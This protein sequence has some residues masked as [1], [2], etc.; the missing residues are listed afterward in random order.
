EL[1]PRDVYVL[2]RIAAINDRLDLSKEAM[3]TYRKAIELEPGFYKPY[4]EFGVFFY[5]R[6]EYSQAADQLHRAIQLA[7]GFYEAYLYLGAAL[8]D[9]GQDQE[10]ETVF[11]ES[12][13]L[14]DTSQAL[15]GLGA[16]KAYQKLD[17]EALE[18]Y[19]RSLKLDPRSYV[20]L[21][22]LGDSSRRLRYM[23]EARNFYVKGWDLALAEL[24]GN[25]RSGY[26]RAYLGY[27]AARLGDPRRAEQETEEALQLSPA[28]RLEFAGRC[29]PMRH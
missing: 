16:I 25:P 8:S 9:M 23:N 14:K 13:K 15:N 28:D 29:L 21:M 22:N 12:L 27:F 2:L 17:S 10:A 4:E 24:E 20:C 6:G 26:A 7:P 5:F 18:F 19:R 11:L 1:E 3:D